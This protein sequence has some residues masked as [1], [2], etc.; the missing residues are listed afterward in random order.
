MMCG[1]CSWYHFLISMMLLSFG[2]GSFITGILA[3]Y[4][5]SGKSRVVGGVL[6]LLGLIA[7]VV[8]LWCS[9][10]LPFLGPPPIQFVGCVLTGIV[11]VLGALVGAAIALGVFLLSIMKT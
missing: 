7:G 8:F 5:G 3:M 10:V 4:F 9:W 1:V 2:F 6:I 11:A